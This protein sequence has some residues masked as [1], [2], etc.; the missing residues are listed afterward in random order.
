MSLFIS[1]FFILGKFLVLLLLI[2]GNSS[3]EVLVFTLEFIGFFTIAL[4]KLLDI[5]IDELLF[6][7]IGVKSLLFD[8]ISLS[9]S[10]ITG[11]VTRFFIVVKSFDFG[12]AF[13][14]VPS[15]FLNVAG[16]LSGPAT[17][18]LG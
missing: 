3:L 6:L 8:S 11:L 15:E 1:L 4:F 2:G 14:E 18:K 12:N 7:D 13:V 16:V 17:S 10:S 5:F 9:D